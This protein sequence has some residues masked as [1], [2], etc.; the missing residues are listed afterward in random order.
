V[1]VVVMVVSLTACATKQYT[2]LVE[3]EPEQVEQLNQDVYRVEYRVS[4]FTSQEQLDRYLQRRC[5][6]LTLREGYDYFHLGQRFDVLML[7]RRT[8]VTVTM[9]K[10]EKPPGSVDL[11]DAKAILSEQP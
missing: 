1:L 6:E 4:A 5:A 8:S 3:A 9:F 10:G 2:P 7:S 11:F